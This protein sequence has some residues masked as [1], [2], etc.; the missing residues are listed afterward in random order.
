MADFYSAAVG[1]HRPL[2]DLKFNQVEGVSSCARK[3]P[4]E[5]PRPDLVNV[6][7]IRVLR[8]IEAQI[9]LLALPVRPFHHTPFTTCMVS[10]GTLALLSACN[11]QFKDRDLQIARDQIRMTVGCMKALGEVWPRTRRNVKEIQTIARHVLG[12]GGK[13]VERKTP[14]LDQVPGL[15]SGNETG[16]GLSSDG[17]QSGSDFLSSLG[18]LDLCGFDLAGEQMVDIGNLDAGLSWWMNDP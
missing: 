12:L 9:R 7:T 17:E 16:T 14:N 8:A 3:P 18:D 13:A 2:S 15:L 11:F 5:I 6:H 4:L 10:E 1:L